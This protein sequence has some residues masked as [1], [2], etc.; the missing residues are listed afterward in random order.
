MK[1]KLYN[2]TDMVADRTFPYDGYLSI[3]DGNYIYVLVHLPNYHGKNPKISGYVYDKTG[4]FWTKDTF[5]KKVS[6]KCMNYIHTNKIDQPV[7]IKTFNTK[8]IEKIM[9]QS[10][11][12]K[13]KKQTGGH[14]YENP[15]QQ[16]QDLCYKG[17]T[18]E[19]HWVGIVGSRIGHYCRYGN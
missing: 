2:H 10:D 14:F 16:T 13:K 11:K 1:I 15:Y 6:N 3:E 19:S 17:Y 12:R 18:D 7:F 4:G 8:A 9:R 5:P